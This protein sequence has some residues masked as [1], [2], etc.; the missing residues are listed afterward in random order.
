MRALPFGHDRVGE[1]DHVDAPLQQLLGHAGGQRGVA[2]HDR[3]DRVLA[4]QDLEAAARAS[5][6]GRV[7]VLFSAVSRSSVDRPSMLERFER[8][9]DDRR[10]DGVGEQVGPATAAAAGR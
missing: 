5:L 6:R 10:G 4:G 1:A 8:R 7:A 9:A 2:E 3:H